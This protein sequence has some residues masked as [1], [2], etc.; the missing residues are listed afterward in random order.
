M[1]VVGR[2]YRRCHV[3][4]AFRGHRHLCRR[5]SRRARAPA[6]C[7]R[8]LRRSRVGSGQRVREI[9]IR[10]ALGAEARQ[11]FRLFVDRGLRLCLVGLVLG[12]A[13]GIGDARV[14]AAVEGREPPP[15]ILGHSALVA[16]FVTAVALLA[17]WIPTRRAARIDP[18]GALRAE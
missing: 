6:L 10:T 11:A 7:Y 18:L 4:T 16:L 17:S 1:N 14:I 15:G 9:G 3:G 13:L 5:W 12:L 2:D 8:P